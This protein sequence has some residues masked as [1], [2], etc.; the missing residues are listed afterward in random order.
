MYV[1]VCRTVRLPYGCLS[2]VIV[3]AR[4]VYCAF[5]NCDV[6]GVTVPCAGSLRELCRVRCARRG[7]CRDIRAGRRKRVVVETERALKARQGWGWG[8]G[9]GRTDTRG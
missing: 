9:R 1:C 4:S 5:V 8:E 7:V 3:T 2:G 6:H